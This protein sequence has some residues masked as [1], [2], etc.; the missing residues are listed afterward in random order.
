MCNNLNNSANNATIIL[1]VGSNTKSSRWRVKNALK[2]LNGCFYIKSASIVYS[3][4]EISGRFAEYSNAVAIAYTHMSQP[5]IIKALKSY[6]C[7]N[8]RT[9]SSKAS[10]RVTIDIDLIAYDDSIL[11]PKELN[12]NYFTIGWNQIKHT[13]PH[14]YMKYRT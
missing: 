3:T 1:S 11:R 5:E 6:E 8:G 12:R 14:N 9:K 13:Y 2:W 10:G 4:P 7:H